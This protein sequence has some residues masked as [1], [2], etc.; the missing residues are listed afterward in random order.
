MSVT[1]VVLDEADRMLDM[2]FEPQI[3]KCMLD[4]RPDRQTVMT[5]ATWNWD[6]QRIAAKYLTDPFFVNVG[7]LDLTA[8]HSVTQQII[9][10]E[11]E[12]KDALLYEMIGQMKPDDK[13]IVF[14][15]KKLV[16]D[17]LS[18]KFAMDEMAVESIHGGREQCAR[19]DAINAFRD[20]EVRVL[21]ATDVASRG[22]DILDV[23]LVVNYDFPKNMEEYV[24][25]V[26][27]TGRAGR[28]GLAVSFISRRDWG[29]SRELIR[30]LE[31]AEQIVPDELRDMAN[32]FDRMK[33]RRAAEGGGGFGGR[34]GGGGGF[35]GRGGG[36]RG[37][38]GN[39]RNRDRDD[40]FGGLSM[41]SSAFMP[42]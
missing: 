8:V 2:G 3:L 33:E 27:R 30:I 23:T 5:S 16:V 28:T 32:R 38:G 36:G 39:R 29:N 34:R 21:L 7:S 41:S 15:G 40:D 25:R 31:E 6:V 24:H 12:E 1:Y 17:Q 9:F 11:E 35:G 13:M 19:E 42:G 10:A 26:G 20:S 14:I 22:L 18:S 37:F 4:V